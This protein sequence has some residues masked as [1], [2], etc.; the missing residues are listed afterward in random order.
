M[1]FHGL[2]TE[3]GW[4]QLEN[5]DMILETERLYLRRQRASDTAALIDLWVDPQVTLFLGGQR[6]RE[7]LREVFEETARDPL[8]EKYDLWPVIEK[9]TGQVIGHCGLLDKEVEGRTEIELNYILSPSVWG[10]GYATE[11]GQAIICYAFEK[12]ELKRLIALIEP[13]NE[14]SKRVALR[15]GMQRGSEIIRPG[16][17]LREV[18]VIE[19]QLPRR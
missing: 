11:I 10:K 7:W 19:A 17:A 1:K 8:A 15:L 9:A 5:S 2:M 12:L 6:D 18:Y 3:K 13:E 4:C 16:G 14:P